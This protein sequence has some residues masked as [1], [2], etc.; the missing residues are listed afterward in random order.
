M[1]FQFGAFQYPGY[2]QVADTPPV[3]APEVTPAGSSKRK[4]QRERYIARYKG[5]DHEFETLAELEVFVEQARAEQSV[6]P[7]RKRTP[8][9]IKL[10]P[11]FVEQVEQVITPPQRMYSMP[12]SAAMAQ[13]RRIEAAM[14]RARVESDED[15]E[16]LLWLM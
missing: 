16:L 15:D 5:E 14:L 10:A 8:V 13:V 3:V 11:G 1:A 9:R 6:Q 2:Q 7:K 12:P 4:R